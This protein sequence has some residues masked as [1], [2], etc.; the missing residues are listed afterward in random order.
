MPLML[1]ACHAQAERIDFGYRLKGDGTIEVAYPVCPDSEVLSAEIIKMTKAEGKLTYTSLWKAD[2]PS[3]KRAADGVFTIGGRQSFEREVTMLR[4]DIP[5]SF[6][7]H[8]REG[9]GPESG[10]ERE[11]SVSLDLLKSR[12][13]EAGEFMTSSGKVMGRREIN[14]QVAC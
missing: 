4:E 5:Q 9:G 7:L 8:V 13:L 2:R 3:S 6:Y 11:A 12:K 10:R 14:E 1:S